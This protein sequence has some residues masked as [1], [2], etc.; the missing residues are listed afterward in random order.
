MICS[1]GACAMSSGTLEDRSSV[2]VN[3]YITENSSQI[4]DGSP[5]GR[6]VRSMRINEQLNTTGMQIAGGRII[7]SYGPQMVDNADRGR[8]SRSKPAVPSAPVVAVAHEAPHES[9]GAG[10]VASGSD[11]YLPIS[12]SPSPPVMAQSLS[13]DGSVEGDA[14]DV[15]EEPGIQPVK[16]VSHRSV[17]ALAPQ[18]AS[19]SSHGIHRPDSGIVQNGL[20]HGIHIPGE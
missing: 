17:H 3:P 12:R 2:D 19:S 8:G 18:V 9:S 11:K 15:R 13:P 7:D 10:V 1:L 4:D 5:V 16:F 6:A 20:H 14:H